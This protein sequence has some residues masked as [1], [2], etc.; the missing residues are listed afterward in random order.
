MRECAAGQR[1]LTTTL[2][3]GGGISRLPSN[4]DMRLP[5]AYVNAKQAL[6]EC[7]RI[8]E[9]KDWSDKAAALASYARMANDDSLL[10]H[11]RRIQAR[12]V[13]RMG[14]LLKQ[15]EPGKGGRPIKNPGVPRPSLGGWLPGTDRRAGPPDL[16]GW[17]PG[18]R[19][20]LADSVGLTEHRR[21]VSLRVANVPGEEFESAVES[22]NPPTVTTLA[23]RGKNPRPVDLVDLGGRDPE[24][25]ALSTDGQGQLRQL[26]KFCG[27]VDAGVVARGAMP[28]E[29]QAMRLDI[30]IIAVISRHEQVEGEDKDFYLLCAWGHVRVV[31]RQVLR[32]YKGEPEVE[33][34]QQ[35]VMPGFKRLQRGYL[36]ERGKESMLVPTDQLKNEE[37]DAKAKE[38]DQMAEGCRL[39][40]LELRRYMMQRRSAAA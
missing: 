5:G 16:D 12:A 29:R 38:Y 7:S 23:E 34:D 27:H 20:E 22:V 39:H 35:I 32:R 17:I 6:T 1:L 15:V 37:L 33:L 40:A 26:A 8:D 36:V 3:H 28:D 31:V 14:E 19:S 2:S 9:C 24:E 21:K 13:R 4:T 10:K 18:T 30:A 11:A 25:F